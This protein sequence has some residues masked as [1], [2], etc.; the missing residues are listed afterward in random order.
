M[1]GLTAV[2]EFIHDSLEDC[3]LNGKLQRRHF[4]A[5]GPTVVKL[6]WKPIPKNKNEMMNSLT[7]GENQIAC[8]VSFLGVND[9]L[10]KYPLV[11]VLFLDNSHIHFLFFT[12]N[13]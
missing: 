13:I 12:Q 2:P 3:S 8:T 7:D 11:F 9:R 5:K 1:K 10:N 4:H 6:L